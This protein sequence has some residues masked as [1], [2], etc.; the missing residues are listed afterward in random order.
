MRRRLTQVF[1]GVVTL[2]LFFP[3]LGYGFPPEWERE[4]LAIHQAAHVLFLA[5]M[6]YFIYEMRRE[7]LQRLQGFRYLIWACALLALWNLDALV[8]HFSECT[9]APGIPQTTELASS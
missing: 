3:R 1:S 6:L 2:V 8:G 4:A 9:A 7:R 5:A